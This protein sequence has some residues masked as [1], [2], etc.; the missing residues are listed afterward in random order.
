[1]KAEKRLEEIVSL[2]RI[3]NAMPVS[4]IASRLEV[5]HM[6]VRR[7]L[8]IL[9]ARSVVRMIHGGAVIADTAGEGG[10]GGQG[11]TAPAV[12]ELPAAMS[13]MTAEKMRIGRAAASMVRRGSSL[14]IDTGST[15]EHIARA[16]PEEMDLSVLCC[17]LNALTAVSRKRGLRIIFAGGYF[18][19]NTLMFESAE[20]IALIRKTRA[21]VAFISARGIDLNLGAT[22][23][24]SYE[25]KTKQALISSAKRRILVADSSKFGLVSATWF[26]D[27]DAF[28]AIV[29]D[30]GLPSP[31]AK[32]IRK[33]GIALIIV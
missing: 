29:T 25:T 33:R 20:G 6:T 17:S 23:A 10:Q 28:D 30:K 3:N 21:E 9:E 11:R 32:Q 24:T 18:H 16:L 15:T 8:R 12:Y 1:M 27:V 4:D 14:S 7:D 26:A 13:E 2:L 31:I 19:A 5:S 22:C